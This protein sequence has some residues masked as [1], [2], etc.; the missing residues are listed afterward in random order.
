MPCTDKVKAAAVGDDEPIHGGAAAEEPGPAEPEA[1]GRMRAAP[2]AEAEAPATT[3]LA[4]F[5][6]DVLEP[7]S[8]SEMSLSSKRVAAAAEGLLVGLPM[9]NLWVPPAKEPTITMKA[10]P[11]M[12]KAVMSKTKLS[13][14]WFS[15]RSVKWWTPQPV[16]NE[17]RV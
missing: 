16:R 3:K 7:V 13:N 17:T 15:W 6:I 10:S 14:V 1:A 11:L 2:E 12:P 8:M 9:L 4:R 5:G